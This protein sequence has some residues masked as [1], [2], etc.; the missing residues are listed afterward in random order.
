MG[1]QVVD[2][3]FSGPAVAPALYPPQSRGSPQAQSPQSPQRHVLTSPRYRFGS[4]L[5][6]RREEPMRADGD[7]DGSFKEDKASRKTGRFDTKTRE[8]SSA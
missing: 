7:A 4:T 5:Y 6:D 3:Q 8:Q 2:F 1:G